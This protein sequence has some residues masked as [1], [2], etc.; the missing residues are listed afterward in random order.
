M[1]FKYTEDMFSE[2][3]LKLYNINNEYI[4]VEI[5]PGDIKSV[6]ENL[7]II[8][9]IDD[10]H[11]IKIIYDSYDSHFFSLYDL[12]FKDCELHLRTDYYDFVEIFKLNMRN[13]NL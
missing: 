13:L 11:F 2:F 8:Y 5:I 7:F 12:K 6:C 10:I 1:K 9:I 4:H 3:I